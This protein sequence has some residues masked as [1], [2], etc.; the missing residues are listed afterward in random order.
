VR[1]EKAIAAVIAGAS[2]DPFAVLGVHQTADGVVARCFVPGAETVTAYALSG[3]EL[4]ALDLRDA[5]GFFE[6]RLATNERQPV[7]YKAANRAAEW[8]VSDAYSFGPV[9]GPMDDYYI[10]EGSHLRLF[11]KL[12]APNLA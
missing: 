9:L 10:A 1:P 11:D 7:R 2:N 8:W 12:G 4:G 6:G 3:K 5:A